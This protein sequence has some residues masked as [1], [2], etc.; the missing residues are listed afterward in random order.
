MTDDTSAYYLH[1]ARIRFL[2]E[3]TEK[4]LSDHLGADDLAFVAREFVGDE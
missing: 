2:N 3:M 4:E 1:A